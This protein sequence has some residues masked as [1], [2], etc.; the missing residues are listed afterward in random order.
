MKK[1]KIVLGL[2]LIYYTAKFT[3]LYLGKQTIKWR[4]ETFLE[5]LLREGNHH[6]L[7]KL[8]PQGFVNGLLAGL[9]QI[10]FTKPTTVLGFNVFGAEQGL[11]DNYDPLLLEKISPYLH[12]PNPSL[13]TNPK[14]YIYNTHQL[15][16]YSP[17][18]LEVY[19][20]KPNVLMASY[21][22]KEKLNNLGLPAIVEETNLTEFMRVN[23]WDY[24]ES[25][26]ASRVF[27]VD[28]KNK[29]DD[30][31]YF[32]DLHRDAVKNETSAV[33]IK[34]KRYARTLFVVGLENP[35]YESNLKLAVK[36]DEMLKAQYPGLSRGVLK[37]QG[38]GVNGVY[39]QDLS[40]R[41]ILLEVGGIDN[42]IEEVLNAITAFADIFYQYVMDD[43]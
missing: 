41:A 31:K 9:L 26:K 36:L 27:M 30:L 34:G 4:H 11:K 37:K 8:K 17:K 40:P 39:N 21:L 28:A 7:T 15:E 5:I 13:I 24:A 35:T 22:L 43:E 25:Y 16:N 1:V 29:Y 12:D 38:K 2:C 32:I 6:F 42:N 20:I 19:Q 14:V 3:Y 23:H 10:D 33:T 18:Y